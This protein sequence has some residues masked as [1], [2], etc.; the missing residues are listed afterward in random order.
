[1]NTETHISFDEM[2]I[3]QHK[4]FTN[5]M[6]QSNLVNSGGFPDLTLLKICTAIKS[7]KIY[8]S[9]IK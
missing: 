1:M 4:T 5:G 3:L 6:L 2:I 8:E 7:I 9:V